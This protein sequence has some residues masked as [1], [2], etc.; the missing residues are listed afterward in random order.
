MRDQSGWLHQLDWCPCQWSHQRNQ[1]SA[2]SGAD[3]TNGSM[4]LWRHPPW[5][6]WPTDLAAAVA[7]QL[8]RRGIGFEALRVELGDWQPEQ[9][10]THRITPYRHDRYGLSDNDF[11]D[12]RLIQW[13]LSTRSE[14]ETQW[15]YDRDRLMRY[16]QADAPEPA[17]LVL[18]SMAFAPDVADPNA[19]G[20]KLEQLKQLS[21]SSVGITV[22]DDDFNSYQP[23][24]TQCGADVITWVR[25]NGIETA[26]AFLH[27]LMRFRKSIQTCDAKARPLWFVDTRYPNLAIIDVIK[28]VSL[29]A[30]A[31]AIDAWFNPVLAELQAISVQ[32]PYHT[33]SPEQWDTSTDEIFSRTID[34]T[35]D[36]LIALQPVLQLGRLGCRDAAQ[37]TAWGLPSIESQDRAARA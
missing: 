5:T 32:S 33:P 26:D 4:L 31:V 7:R 37:A 18:P 24:I 21:Q 1:I 22:D 27:A 9:S 29:G 35:L 10:T 2:A 6:S 23:I 19:I 15:W 34:A 12:T 28:L 17:N 11:D 20:K 14:L 25:P 16:E 8:D 13:Q 30:T 36:D 3:H